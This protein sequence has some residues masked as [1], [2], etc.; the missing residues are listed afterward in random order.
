MEVLRVLN[1]APTQLHLYSWV[2]LQAFRLLCE[3]LSLKPTPRSFLHFF[4]TRPG[5]R[6]GW[7]S[8]VGQSKNSFLHP[9]TTSYKRFKEGFFKVVI[10]EEGR[11]FFFDGET[12][13]FPFLL[14]KEF[15]MFLYVVKKL[16][17]RGRP[18]GTICPGWASP[19]D[20]NSG[21]RPCLLAL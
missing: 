7:V 9:F 5:D 21:S 3:V 17:D 6:I 4:G 16:D 12:P 14:H 11:S 2:A 19:P 15:D 10:E 18:G 8:L 20:P 1:V 13:R